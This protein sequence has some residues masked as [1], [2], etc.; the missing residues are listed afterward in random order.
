MPITG[1]SSGSGQL[2]NQEQRDALEVASCVA[3]AGADGARIAVGG[4]I[5]AAAETVT[6]KEKKLR[7]LRKV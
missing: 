5:K 6:D 2:R 7:N 4:A 3:S 1:S